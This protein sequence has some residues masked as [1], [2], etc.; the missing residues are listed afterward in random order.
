MFHTMIIM[1]WINIE[2][3]AHELTI[4]NLFHNH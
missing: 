2:T 1:N 4:H 3:Q